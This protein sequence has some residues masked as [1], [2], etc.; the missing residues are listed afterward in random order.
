MHFES[1]LFCGPRPRAAAA[2]RVREAG[3]CVCLQ[4][5]PMSRGDPVF[6]D[7]LHDARARAALESE[8]SGSSWSS[9]GRPAGSSVGSRPAGSS[10]GSR[11][12]GHEAMAG[13]RPSA[14]SVGSRTS[15]G[16]LQGVL[17]VLC[18]CVFVGCI[19]LLRFWCSGLRHGA[20]AAADGVHIVLNPAA[21]ARNSGG[22]GGGG[23]RARGGAAA[24]AAAAPAG[25]GVSPRRVLGLFLV[26]N[27]VTAVLTVVP[28]VDAAGTYAGVPYAG[29]GP[30]DVIRLV[31]PFVSAVLQVMI[32]LES[33]RAGC[34]A[35][36]LP[37]CVT[38]PVSSCSKLW[39][40]RLRV[41]LASGSCSAWRCTS[42]FAVRA[43]SVSVCAP[44]P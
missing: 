42:R 30:N 43:R 35:E 39:Q 15:A 13:G 36:A 6:G 2:H 31:E 32:L 18:V 28:V 27:V 5:S 20:A 19:L 22:G 21:A 9:R 44:V 41:P 25:G 10:V 12:S 7:S 37:A 3:P 1:S 38:R 26:A 11:G 16:D 40:G 29:Y 17:R 24:A 34:V 23:A 14:S 4:A 33:V 8:P